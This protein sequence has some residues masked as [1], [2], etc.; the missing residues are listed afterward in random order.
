MG[1]T[2][3]LKLMVL[4]QSGRLHI[5][6]A[7]GERFHHHNWVNDAPVN[8]KTKTKRNQQ[9]SGT[10]QTSQ[11][12]TE[13]NVMATFVQVPL[14][15]KDKE[16]VVGS[17]MFEEGCA[18]LTK[19]SSMPHRLFLVDNFNMST[20]FRE[21]KSEFLDDVCPTA[22]EVLPAQYSATT[23]T[24]VV[25]GMNDQPCVLVMSRHRDPFVKTLLNKDESTGFVKLRYGPD[26]QTL[27]AFSRDRGGVLNVFHA[28]MSAN[29]LQFECRADGSVESRTPNSQEEVREPDEIVYCGNECIMLYW[30]PNSIRDGDD[31]SLLIMIDCYGE[32]EYFTY[33]C[34]L[35]LIQECD[36]TRVISNHSVELYERVPDSTVEVF[37]IGSLESSALLYD[38]YMDY[39]NNRSTS[40]K[41]IRDIRYNKQ[42]TSNAGEDLDVASSSDKNAPADDSVD[43]EI[44]ADDEN[45]RQACYTLVDAACREMLDVNLQ[46]Q[47]LNA[48]TYGRTF[49]KNKSRVGLGKRG[50]A[51]DFMQR[52]KEIRVLNEVRRLANMP[53]TYQQYQQLS[54]PVLIAR[55]SELHNHYLA[56][57]ISEYLGIKSYDVL[58]HWACT[59]AKMAAN[60]DSS[61]D[62]DTHL[63]NVINEQLLPHKQD[64]SYARIAMQAFQSGKKHLA[65]MLLKEDTNPS[66][67]IPLYLSMHETNE[68]MDKAI[69]SNDSDLMYMIVLYMVK[70]FEQE[71]MFQMIKDKPLMMQLFTSYNKYRLKFK[72]IEKMHHYLNNHVDAGYAALNSA[73]KDYDAGDEE[74]CKTFAG[75]LERAEQHFAKDGYHDSDRKMALKQ[76]EL[77]T[78]QMKV[79]KDHGVGTIG[80]TLNDTLFEVMT[81]TSIKDSTKKDLLKK[82][83]QQFS[84]S[85]K[86]YW[87]IKVRALASM[88]S[89]E[90]LIKFA[91]EKPS[92]IGYEP[93]TDACLAAGKTYEAVKCI[94]LITDPRVKVDYYIGLLKFKEAIEVA[95]S[96]IDVDLLSIYQRL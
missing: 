34:P 92:P 62:D 59:K 91:V 41:T 50:H 51:N 23:H 46:Q 86:R 57:K 25:L 87:T 84:V 26:K 77:L 38:A 3:D 79:N 93:F 74:N 14:N 48:A 44:D 72:R 36:A 43:H 6:N 11:R 47:L 67:Q 89:W 19:G 60:S 65:K 96:E 73:Y 71:Y 16:K 24:E 28:N 83:K 4:T 53:L 18:I 70:F 35:H 31:A 20:P 15:I 37:R 85:D 5:F 64:V 90:Q 40:I 63:F 10:D 68:A 75:W 66:E 81:S 8:D 9:N 88:G 12:D 61:Q 76:R 58:V 54:A 49:L 29:L 82:I 21:L 7:H 2:N 32:Y 80:M 45:L 56:T 27:A 94:Q 95:V 13:S 42:N 30:K 22:I 55:L 52:C 39:K 1:W 17:K 69:G 33:E 78:M